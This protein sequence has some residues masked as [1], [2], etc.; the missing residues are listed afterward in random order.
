MFMNIVAP[1]SH[2]IDLKTAII[3]VNLGTPDTPTAPAVR[4]Y[5]RQFLSDKRVVEIPQFIWGIILNLFVIPLRTKRVAHAYASIWQKDSPLR[6]ITFEQAT[7]LQQKIDAD[8]SSGKIKNAQ[9]YPAMTYGNPALQELLS[10]L[11]EQ[12]VETVILLPLYP[13]YSA[14]TTGAVFDVLAKWGLTQR[15][16]P[17]IHFIKDY[18]AHP[19]YIK[20][21]VSHIQHYQHVHGKPEKLMMSFHGIPKPYEDKGDP[22]AK[23]CKCTAAQIAQGLGL[24]DDEW[25]CSFQSRFGRQ[26]WVK[27]YTSEVLQRWGEQGV[28]SVQVISPSFSADCLETL[29]ELAVENRD[30]FM[31]AGKPTANKQYSYIPALNA[32]S[33]HIELMFDLVKKYLLRDV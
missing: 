21:L 12:K 33:A 5:L 26:E 25:I 29:E 3:L 14:S 32:D 8:A 24:K 22:Y 6:Q 7:A 18:F 30:I 1:A 9:V 17:N 11:S 13:Q 15:N 10:S 23:R 16:L 2:P 27:P 20:V 28:S 4:R 31:A 19:L